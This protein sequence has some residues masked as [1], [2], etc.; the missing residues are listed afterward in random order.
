MREIVQL[1]DYNGK[2]RS[3]LLF[4]NKPISYISDNRKEAIIYTEKEL[5]YAISYYKKF[6]IPVMVERR[7][8]IS[9]KEI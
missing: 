7:K 6:K 9:H 5:E 8:V 1:V 4:D 2:Y 3:I